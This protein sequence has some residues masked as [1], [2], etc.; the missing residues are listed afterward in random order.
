V[1]KWIASNLQK[2]GGTDMM[3]TS[4]M[5]LLA[6]VA[7]LGFSGPANAALTSIGTATYSGSSYNLIYEDDQK[8]IWLDYSHG[9]AN[10]QSQRDW[11]TGLNASGV[12]AYN[13][14][15]GLN[16]TWGGEWRLPSTVDGPYVYGY[17]GTTTG[18]YNVPS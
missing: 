15:P 10:W 17:D 5:L 8:L 9:Y 6:L 4:W 16:V 14:N 12:L 3:K 1:A 18:G 11:A 13:L 7:V 2:K